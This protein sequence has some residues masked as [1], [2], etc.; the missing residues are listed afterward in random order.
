MR[1]LVIGGGIAGMA[2]SIALEQAGLDPLVL[3]QSPQ[4]A[5]IGSGIGMHANAMR[6][7]AQLGAAD[8]VRASGVRID[9]GEW[10]RMDD[11]RRIF[12][13]D[14][15]GMAEHY[16]D[17]Y[18]CM[19]RADLLESLARQVPEE[20]VRLGARLV[21]LEERPDG[22]VA[23]LADGDEVLGDVLVGA[24][25]LRSAVRKQIFPEIEP[26]YCGYVAWR[27]IVD[28]EAIPPASRE[29]LKGGYWFVLPPNEMFLSYEVP[30]KDP[31]R[32]PGRRDWN[33]VWY[34]P[35][36]DEAFR[37][38]CTDASGR[39]H[40]HGIPPPLIR[41]EAIAK[42]KDDARALLAPHLATLVESSKPF[43]QPIYDIESPRLASGR[44][45]L[46][47][48]AAFVARPHIGA[49]VTKAALDSLCLY[50]SLKQGKSLGAALSRYDRLRTGYGRACVA[51]GR[52]LG[53]YI[54]ARSRPQRPWTPEQLD[55][56][57][58]RVLSE[59]A[60]AL[61]EIP[62]LGLEL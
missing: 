34:R 33:Y 43:F 54:E 23:R 28:E 55:Q 44:V 38:L 50:N 58:E 36:T 9:A 30:S 25:G 31:L 27:S 8:F 2:T 42:F 53:S 19:H 49:G 40:E 39:R 11:G 47:G 60:L 46:L 56:R 22:V 59:V 62:E 17:V 6:V 10:R 51:R 12:A 41:R 52:R 37:E 48:D 32:E 24:D 21:G 3:E 7:L 18:I 14:Y 45:A 15:T 5:E 35:V 1:A 16:G 61:D 20:R 26:A 57:P 13:Q 4:L 29:W